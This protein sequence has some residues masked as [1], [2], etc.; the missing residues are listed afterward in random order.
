MIHHPQGSANH[1]PVL[2]L[3]HIFYK[4]ASKNKVILSLGLL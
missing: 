1:I 2:L 4:K 3:Y